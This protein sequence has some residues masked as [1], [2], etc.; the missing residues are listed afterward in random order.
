MDVS[1]T[2]MSGGGVGPACKWI[3]LGAMG[4]TY[5]D[6]GVALARTD[7]SYISQSQW[8]CSPATGSHL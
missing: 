1:G 8:L 5:Q 3:E 2:H 4:P 6:G 7:M